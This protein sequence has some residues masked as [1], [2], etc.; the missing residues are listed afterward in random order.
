MNGE[1][2]KHGGPCDVRASG[3]AMLR[4]VGIVHAGRR[5]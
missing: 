1:L 5:R 4:I 3:Q 2:A